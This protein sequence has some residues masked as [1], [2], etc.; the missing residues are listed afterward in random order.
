MKVEKAAQMIVDLGRFV[1]HRYDIQEVIGTGGMGTVYRATDRL[2]SKTVAL[3]QVKLVNEDGSPFRHA[4]SDLRLALAQEFKVLASLRHPHIISVLDYGFS[5]QAHPFFTMRFLRDPQ[6]PVHA[7]WQRPLREKIDV[8]VQVL[9]ALDYLH[10]RNIIHRDLKP[11]N[12]ALEDGQVKLLDFGLSVISSTQQQDGLANVAGTLTY[13]APELLDGVPASEQSD[14]YSLGVIAYEMLTGYKLFQTESPTALIRQKL[15]AE[16][17][18]SL[19]ENANLAAVVWRLISRDPQSRYETAQHAIIELCRAVEAPPPAESIAIRESYLQAARFVGRDDELNILADAL[20]MATTG[21]GS[22]WL[23]GGESGVGKSR[24]L[25]ELR[26][27][28]L[29]EG[30]LVLK[31]QAT[32]SLGTPFHIWREPLRRLV[33]HTGLSDEEA[34]I[35]RDLIP[36]V[37][38]LMGRSIPEAPSPEES[39]QQVLAQTIVGLFQRQ[40][41]LVVLLLEDLHWT[42]ESLLPL[43][44]LVEVLDD[45][46]LLIIGS[47]RDDE[48]PGL[49]AE[50]PA[51]Q[52]LRLERLRTEHVAAL[53]VSMLGEAGRLPQIVNLLHRETEGNVFFIIEVVRALAQTAGSLQDIGYQTLPENV[54]AGGVRQVV[55]RRLAKLP[56]EAWHPLAYAAVAGRQLDLAV[57]RYLLP[58]ADFD[59]W[60]A[61]AANA[62][63]L[64]ADEDHWRFAHDKLREAMLAELGTAQRQTMHQEIAEAIEAIYPYDRSRAAALTLH[65]GE[66]GNHEAEYYY[67]NVAGQYA[68]AIGAYRDALMFFNRALLRALELALHPVDLAMLEQEIAEAHWSLHDTELGV[69]HS[70]RA[71]AYLRRDI[72]LTDNILLLS[73]QEQTLCEQLRQ[74]P[75]PTEDAL[76]DFSPETRLAVGIIQAAYALGKGDWAAARMLFDDLGDD[77]SL[78]LALRA[79]CDY[80]MGQWET[81]HAT[82]SALATQPDYHAWGA[83]GMARCALARGN[84]AQARELAQQA[85]ATDGLLRIL[86]DGVWLGCALAEDDLSAAAPH[87]DALRA[88]VEAD[89]PAVFNLTECY[90]WLA[91]YHLRL[92]GQSGDEGDK[93]TARAT[94][95]HL[96]RFA[97]LYDLSRP[98]AWLY[99]GEFSRLND[100][101]ERAERNLRQAWQEAESLD[102][103]YYR[104]HAAYHLARLL[105]AGDAERATLRQQA[106]Q[107]YDTLGAASAAE[108]ARALAV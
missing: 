65:W 61:I 83:L 42:V 59:R 89:A 46:P 45:L 3:K 91:D 82:F 56:D 1:H 80:F 53:S 75:A 73:S 49:P 19:L 8:I 78:I 86:Y 40:R 100:A 33:L 36:D 24:L 17:D 16:Y 37:E 44:L 32:M 68:L 104:A 41:D 101:F 94:L 20:Q 81:A 63:V 71:L 64:E 54:F 55:Q 85:H 62:A 79:E 35:L 90:A 10:R 15:D 106:I 23:V 50:L 87:G 11:G 7:T 22:A 18:M 26:T 38:A 39:R 48:R 67:A 25:D 43:R 51:M 93:A 96:Q 95:R 66:A 84:P 70:L 12:I 14:L 29:V 28:A 88:V 69:Q 103:P 107:L 6:T 13:M 34:A 60:L 99:Q 30:A 97:Q 92:W 4:H 98:L 102:V 52:L 108:A 74:H 57:L 31:G 9:Q 77:T 27:L 72:P 58:S 76:A 105:P 5:E 2:T 47:F 21:R